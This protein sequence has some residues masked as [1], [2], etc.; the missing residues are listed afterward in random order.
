M[1]SF[2]PEI[3]ICALLALVGLVGCENGG[4]GGD[5]LVRDSSGVRIVENTTGSWG[6]GEEWTLGT[7]PIFDVGNLDGDSTQQLFRVSDAARLPDGRIVIANGGSQELFFFDA[8]GNRTQV[9]GGRGGGP[10]EFESLSWHQIL[11]DTLAVANRRPARLSLFDLDGN[12]AR[13]V[14]LSGNMVGVFPDGTVLTRQGALDGLPQSGLARFESSLIRLAQD[15]EVLDSLGSIPGTEAHFDVGGGG[16]SIRTSPLMRSTWTLVH[17]DLYF[18]AATDTYEVKVFGMDGTL[19][20][21]IRK[22]HE[23]RAID[24]AV[25]DSYMEAAL[26]DA[27]D[28][29][30]L[31]EARISLGSTELPPTLPAFGWSS[32]TQ[33]A[34]VAIDDSGNLWVAEYGAFDNK[35]PR[36]S[37]FDRNGLLLGEVE[38]PVAVEPMHIGHDFVLGRIHDDFD[39]EHIVMYEL[40]KP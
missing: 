11:K 9:A 39:V 33:Y 23:L 36:W 24:D 8:A 15:G 10:G 16:V 17:N 27:G 35:K 32:S 13:S 25:V 19:L 29:Q 3:V 12:F 22:R 38:F 28:D 26:E 30:A 37:V 1:K 40:L 21:S 18:V 20:S 2:K 5:Y 34:P 7:T 31:R 6:E 4:P 14:A